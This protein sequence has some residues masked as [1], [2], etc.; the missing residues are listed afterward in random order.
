MHA[1]MTVLVN[2]GPWLPVPPVAYGG[3]ENVVA[4][5]VPEL[6]R[7]GVRVVLATV[8]ESQLVADE[9]VSAFPDGQFRHLARPYNQVG[10]IAHAHMQVVVRR[11]RRAD[12]DVVHDHLEIVGPAT[13]AALGP[14]FPPALH[15]LHWDPQRAAAFYRE[16]DA[17]GR[18]WVN[19]VSDTQ[20]AQAPVELQ[21]L[22]LGAVPLATSIPSGRPLAR[23]ERSDHLLVLGRICRLKGQHLAARVARRTGVPLV[24]AGPVGRAAS[25]NEIDEIGA[26][27]EDVTYWRKEVAPLVDGRQVRWVGA[28]G[29]PEKAA[30]LGSAR[31]LLMPVQWEEP[32]ATV[33]AEALAAG[34]PVIALRRGVLPSLVEHGVTGF[35]A[36]DEDG[37]VAAVSQLDSIDVAACRRAAVERF[38]PAVMAER[39]LALYAEVQR[40]TALSTPTPLHEMITYT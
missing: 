4:T 40:R 37:L 29:G 17:R 19:G 24:L 39:Y 7:R 31:A 35:V 10:A 6:R 30:L 15:T 16:F 2:A 26:A 32:G 23:S 5:L 38:S 18:V 27:D 3:L 20:L 13:L 9:I 8:D 34:T 28:V 1:K 36:D 22:S 33:V 14:E 12:V 25:I 21:R 11:L